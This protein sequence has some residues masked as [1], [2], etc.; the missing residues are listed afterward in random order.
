MLKSKYTVNKD[1][2]KPENIKQT[3]RKDVIDIICVWAKQIWQVNNFI[4]YLLVR[5][6]NKFSFILYVGC[7]NFK[8]S[9]SVNYFLK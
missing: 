7:T 9:F 3:I 6:V 2:K 5:L 8:V 1:V 4:G